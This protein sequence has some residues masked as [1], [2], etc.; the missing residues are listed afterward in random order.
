[1]KKIN[2]IL[3]SGAFSTLMLIQSCQQPEADQATIDAKVTEAYN[4]EKMKVENEAATACEDAINAQVKMVQDSLSHLSAKAQAD[5]LAKTQRELKAAQMK[6]EALKKKAVADAKKT[7]EKVKTVDK[8]P[9]KPVLDA[10]GNQVGTAVTRG[11]DVKSDP[12]IK[13]DDKG[14]QQG[15]SVTR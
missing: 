3:V 11:S 5:L 9:A 4:A 8:T 14:N 13:L 6:A 10:K 12:A 1:M 15:T 2:L 7:A